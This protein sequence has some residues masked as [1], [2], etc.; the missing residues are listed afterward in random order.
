MKKKGIKKYQIGLN[1]ASPGTGMVHPG[2]VAIDPNQTKGMPISTESSADPNAKSMTDMTQLTGNKTPTFG[3][4]AK[5][6]GQKTAGF[7]A[8]NSENI[9]SAAQTIMPLLM[10]KPDANAKPYKKGSKLIKYQ[11]GEKNLQGGEFM[12]D[13]VTEK[14]KAIDDAIKA[15]VPSTIQKYISFGYNPDKNKEPEYPVSTE[16]NPIL[17]KEPKIK[18]AGNVLFKEM[19]LA[20]QKQYRAGIASGR[21]FNV[22]GIGGKY[23]A[24]NKLQQTQPTKTTKTIVKT[25]TPASNIGGNKNTA[26]PVQ[27][28]TQ[29]P[30]QNTK[31]TNTQNTS[32][33]TAQKNTNTKATTNTGKKT[34]PVKT[35]LKAIIPSKI[36]DYRTQNILGSQ[37]GELA[38]NLKTYGVRSPFNE[39]GGANVNYPLFETLH[40]SR[41]GKKK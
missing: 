21:E 8:N 23:G 31:Q 40:N 15:G 19:T 16:A 13:N 25:T 28:N 10:K 17:Y 39:S 26:K 14:N 41:F 27:K 3:D 1:W 2:N 37:R 20:Q 38:K 30:A 7:I 35:P 34:I 12:Y 29:T 6:F 18:M 32:K 11:E 9:V 5:A 22:E 33:N 4:K 24:T 36:M